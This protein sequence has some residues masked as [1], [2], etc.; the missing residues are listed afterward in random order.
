MFVEQFEEG[1]LCMQR[2]IK[3]L[4]YLPCNLLKFVHFG[5]VCFHPYMSCWGSWVIKTVMNDFCFDVLPFG[6]L[7]SIF[8]ED[9]IVTQGSM[10]PI[11]ILWKN[12]KKRILNP[13]P[14]DINSLFEVLIY[15]I[16]PMDHLLCDASECK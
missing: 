14:N 11:H 15:E 6:R 4:R 10:L 7:R 8:M 13:H 3:C 5:M 16:K 2:W 9:D 1:T 12:C